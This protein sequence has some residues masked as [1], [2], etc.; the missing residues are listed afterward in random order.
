MNTPKSPQESVVVSRRLVMPDQLNPNGTLFGGVLMAWIDST[1]F[2]CAERHAETPRVVTASVDRLEF[3]RPLR[4]GDHTVLSARVEWVG[5]TSMALE[6]K[7]E[8]EGHRLGDRAPV[9]TAHLTFVALDADGRPTVISPLLLETH[10]DRQRFDAASVRAKVYQ[11]FR[12]WRE[13]RELPAL[14]I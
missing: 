4:S 6:V 7:V 14:A 1:G 5:R 2:M 10:E 12:R 9:A 8:R 3:L 11:R 13:R